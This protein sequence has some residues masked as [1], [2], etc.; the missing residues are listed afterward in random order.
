MID[1]NDRHSQVLSVAR[2]ILQIQDLDVLLERILTE[3]RKFVNADAGSLYLKEGD[4]LKFSYTQN[5][6]LQA[7]LEPGHSEGLADAVVEL[8]RHA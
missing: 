3:A 1:S 7:K 2:E 5:E 4:N 6:T 8:L